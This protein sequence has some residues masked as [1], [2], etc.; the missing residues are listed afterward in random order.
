MVIYLVS[1]FLPKRCRLWRQVKFTDSKKIIV[2]CL[3]LQYS[4]NK[5]PYKK[6]ES[7]DQ[8]VVLVRVGVLVTGSV[9]QK[10]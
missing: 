3:P 1:Y 10:R 6:G 7:R 4:D 5:V 2:R 8:S 9:P